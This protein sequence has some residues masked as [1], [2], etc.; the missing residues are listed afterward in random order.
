MESA[1]TNTRRWRVADL[2][3]GV[4]AVVLGVGLGSLFSHVFSRASAWIALAGVLTHGWGMFDKHR[5][6]KGPAAAE[7]RWAAA[8]YWICW[9][10]LAFLALAL[11]VR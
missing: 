10:T 7:P 9:L 6:E 11:V 4:G 2:T 3:S 8:L 5:L 1:L